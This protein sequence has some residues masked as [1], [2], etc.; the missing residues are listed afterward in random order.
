MKQLY[1]IC[2]A[3]TKIWKELPNGAHN[4][5]VAEPNYFGYILHFVKDHVLKES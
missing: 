2:Q 4:D 5:T 3:P 1:S